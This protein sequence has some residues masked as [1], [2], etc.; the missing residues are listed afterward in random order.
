[1]DDAAFRDPANAN[2]DLSARARIRDAAILE[3]ATQGVDGTS[4]RGIARAAGVSPG[5]VQHHFRNKDALRAACDE[6]VMAL[7]MHI[8]ETGVIGGGMGDPAF[9][10]GAIRSLEPAMRYMARAL[11]DGGPAANSMFDAVFTFTEAYIRRGDVGVPP[12]DDADIPAIAAVQTAMQL[13][14]LM[15]QSHAY[16]VLGGEAGDPVTTARM[17][18]A[19][20]KLTSDLVLDS[21]LSANIRSGLQSWLDA[22]TPRDTESDT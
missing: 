17:G 2:P 6:H 22:H 10:A 21:E 8:K 16:R 15:L 14:L 7:M 5:L 19:R 4:I 1:M 3:F 11:A 20:L 9:I 13:G 18:L 12:P